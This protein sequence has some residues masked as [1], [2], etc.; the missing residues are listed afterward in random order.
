MS[1]R[2]F[3]YASA[4]ILLVAVAGTAVI[5]P[6]PFVT[7]APGPVFDILGEHDGEP[8]L[9]IEGTRSYPTTGELDMTTVA[10][11][12]GPSGSISVATAIWGL[13]TPD[14]TVLPVQARYPSGD[15]GQEERALEQQVFSQSQ[16]DALAAAANYLHRP[17]TDAVVSSVKPGSPSDG[18]LQPGDVIRSVDGHRVS[19]SGQV[20]KQVSSRPPGNELNLRVER[21][22]Q[23]LDE[24]IKTTASPDDSDR[25][26]IGITVGG[27]YVSNFKPVLSLPDIGGPS[28]GLMLAVA[29]VD[30]LTPEDLLAGRQV[31]GT[32][33]IKPNGEV[34]EI[35]GI[36][37]KILAASRAG[38]QLFLAPAGNCDDVVG[39][40]QPE[41]PI[42]PV[43]TLSEAVDA[44][45]RWQSG[46]EL[47]TCPAS[48]ASPTAR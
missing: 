2:Q 10:E 28:A 26:I 24:T 43:S 20:A 34:G 25:A 40:Q 7:L 3:W 27:Q 29:I 39:A 1:R 46:D 13:L 15:P 6:A 19:S 45:K 11:A 47:P 32:G 37:K 21:G 44:I 9:K 33:T 5:A 17:V 22:G 23:R 42:V 12:G 36:D 35:G 18:K 48:L 4:W 8:V 38:V 14:V 16:S 31:A 41:L 30:K